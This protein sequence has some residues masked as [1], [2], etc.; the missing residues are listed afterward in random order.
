MMAAALSGATMTVGDLLGPAAGVRANI[1]ISDLVLDSRDVLPGAAFVAVPG[2]EAHGLDFAADALDRGAVV[3][4][5][6]PDGG[7]EPPPGASVAVANLARRLGELGKRF[8]ARKANP[9][10]LIGIT[11]TNGKTTVAYVIA[12]ALTRL[13]R[14]CGY[15]GTLGYGIPPDLSEHRLTTPDVLTLNKEISLMPVGDIALEVSSHALSQN[16]LDG[17]NVRSAVFTNLT[18]DHLDAHGDFERYAQAKTM[19]FTRPEIDNVV[20]N[21]DDAFAAELRRHIAPSARVLGISTAAHGDADLAA[22]IV[23]SGVTGLRLQISGAYGAATLNS[24]L[25]GR[26]NAENLLLA[27][28]ALLNLDVALREA[29]AALEDCEPPPGRMETFPGKGAMPSVVVDYAHTPDALARVLD[30]LA[31]QT[32]GQIWCVFGCGGDR[33]P[34]KRRLMGKV[35]A[36]ASH[37]VLTDDNVRNEDPD[38]IVAAIREGIGQHP[39]VRIEHDRAR[40]I[41]LAIRAASPE[42]VVLVAGKGHEH[43]QLIGARRLP[44]DDRAVVAHVLGERT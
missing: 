43:W 33:D 35:A 44:F 9:P 5:Y 25:I 17:I 8:Y 11:G 16:R 7:H 37:I 34:G 22:A 15:I 12:Q 36:Q 39:D 21:L 40:A 20:L 19:L 31:N 13:Q 24:G 23:E 6:E 30:T 41:E 27:L 29:C 38:A 42:D 3:V 2:A 10:A 18:R 1:E 4:L 32:D 26:F 14:T 28:G